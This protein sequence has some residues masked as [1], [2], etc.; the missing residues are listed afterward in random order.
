[1]GTGLF[2]GITFSIDGEA[3]TFYLDEFD[4]HIVYTSRCGIEATLYSD[5]AHNNREEI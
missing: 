4:R 3:W 1:M 2:C 5:N